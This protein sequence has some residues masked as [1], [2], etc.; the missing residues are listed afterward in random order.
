M[1]SKVVFSLYVMI[2][3]GIILCGLIVGSIIYFTMR[4]P[5]GGIIL[6]VVTTGLLLLGALYAPIYVEVDSNFL[7]VKSLLKRRRLRL[8]DI[9]SLELFQPTMGAIRIFASGGF[10]GY[11][12]LFKEGDVGNYIAF[13]G[14][15][16]DCFMIKMKNG[17]KYVFGC[18]NPKMMVDEIRKRI[19]HLGT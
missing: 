2:I 9:K 15:S 1:K 14:K 8:E 10:M 6:I 17:D 3:T 7:S 11:W 12:G 16:S 19:P 5:L 18:K 4:E 13:F